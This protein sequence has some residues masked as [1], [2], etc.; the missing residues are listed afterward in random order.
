M[1]SDAGW[2]I[3]VVEDEDELDIE[4]RWNIVEG[5]TYPFLS[6]KEAEPVEEDDD[7][8][9]GGIFA[10]AGL[11]LMGLV[12]VYLVMKDDRENE[13]EDVLQSEKADESSEEE[14]LEE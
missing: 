2:D 4:Y 9:D 8:I 13:G 6:G 10:A 5:E 11:I 7:P 12:V 14:D 3:T 1:F